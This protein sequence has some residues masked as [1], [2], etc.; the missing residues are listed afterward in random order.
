MDINI[1][2][3]NYAYKANNAGNEN[4]GELSCVF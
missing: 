2:Y 4:K 3:N 1:Y